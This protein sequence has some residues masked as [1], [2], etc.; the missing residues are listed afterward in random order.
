MIEKKN[1]SSAADYQ[2]IAD[3]N[4]EGIRLGIITGMAFENLYASYTPLAELKYFNSMSDMVY[5][6]SN[7]QI[8]GFLFDEPMARYLANH[9]KGITFLEEVAEPLYDYAFILGNS[10]FDLELQKQLNEYMEQ[11]KGNGF[12][13]RLYEKWFGEEEEKAKVEFP[14]EGANGTVK[15]ATNSGN[16]PLTYVKDGEL[17]GLELDILAH[18]CSEFGYSAEVTDMDFSALITSVKSGR[19]DI[20]ASFLA[21]TAERLEAVRFSEPYMSSGA[22]MVIRETENETGFFQKLWDSFERTFIREARWKLILQGIVTTLMISIGAVILGTAL[23]FGICLLRRINSKG[24]HLLTTVYI[25]LMQ[26]TPVL[27]I[28]MIL[29]YIVFAKSNLSGE[30]VAIIAFALNFAAY[31]SEIFRTG[32]ESVDRGQMEA[33]LAIGFT[34]TKAFFE[35][36]LPQAAENFLPVYKGEFISLVK[37]TSVVGY[38]AVQD[39]TKMSDIIRSRTYEAFFPLIS[40]ALIYFLLSSL[41][42]GLLKFLDKKITPDRKHRTVKGVKQK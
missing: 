25:R 4:K 35:I 7:G 23:G 39:L 8:E 16:P 21:I 36:V 32:I 11:I 29:Y 13:D 18:F 26:G 24:I 40:T 37:M 9:A 33:A 10:G 27:V 15:I 12:Y 34:K 22:Y 42:T 28:L 5:A 41:L 6:L 2:T 17:A 3:L 14:R 38:I 30:I 31:S 19:H 20:A 1:A